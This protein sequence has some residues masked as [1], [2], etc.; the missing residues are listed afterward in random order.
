VTNNFEI[1]LDGSY[2]YLDK[3]Q[4]F[5]QENFKFL[6]FPDDEVYQIHSE[7]L[8]RIETGEFLK[9][10]VHWGMD[11]HFVPTFL[12]IEKSLGTKYV[13]EVF[14]I[15]HQTQECFY[16]LKNSIGTQEFKRPFGSKHHLASPSFATAALFTLS[17]KFN[18]TGRTPVTLI[19][20]ANDWVYRE[21]P[22][23]KMVFA[24]FKTRD[25]KDFNLNGTTLTASH[26]QVHEQDMS[27]NGSGVDIWVSK[28]FA[29]P[30]MMQS[31]D[32]KIITNFLKKTF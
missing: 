19:S 15:E 29:V 4:E 26:L 24:E 6:N 13:E 18:A 11:Y 32:K 9:I 16:S 23:E 8:S 21:P 12:R 14:R 27:H 1:L 22:I 17:K 3:E 10:L 28:H 2:K 5:A 31:E 25:I 20:S 30:Y 7:I